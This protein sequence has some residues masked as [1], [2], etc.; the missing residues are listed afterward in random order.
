MLMGGRE[1]RSEVSQASYLRRLLPDP[2]MQRVILG[3]AIHQDTPM[4]HGER[5]D[6]RS[7]ST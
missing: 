6:R 4:V 1:Y 3:Y 2:A 5:R 7:M